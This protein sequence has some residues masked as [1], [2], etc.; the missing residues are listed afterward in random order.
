MAEKTQTPSFSPEIN[1]LNRRLRMV[2]MKIMKMEERLTS[3]ENL[4]RELES[5]IKVLRDIYDRKIVELKGELSS[6]TEKIEMISRS[7]EQ[8]VN[9]NEFQKIKLFLDVFNPLKSSFITK[10]ELEAKLEELKK[11]ILRQENKI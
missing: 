11:D 6:I 7:S 9:K 5:D 2:E 8:F 3:I 1:E 10:E 4:T